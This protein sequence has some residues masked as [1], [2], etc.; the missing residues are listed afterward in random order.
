MESRLEQAH[1]Q[2]ET[3]SLASSTLLALYRA[4]SAVEDQLVEQVE[5]LIAIGDFDTASQ[6]WSKISEFNDRLASIFGLVID[7]QSAETDFEEL[8]DI[9]ESCSKDAR[10]SWGQALLFTTAAQRL[11]G[12]FAEAK[13]AAIEAQEVF[14]DLSEDGDEGDKYLFAMISTAKANRL[15]STAHTQQRVFKLEDAAV[16]YLEAK[17]VFEKLRD[18]LLESDDAPPGAIAALLYDL[19]EC[20]M[21]AE[22]VRL[23]KSF[24]DGNFETAIN[25][26]HAM[27][28]ITLPSDNSGVPKFSL[29]SAMVS[30]HDAMANLAYARAELA[31]N[32]REWDEALRQLTE[33]ER[34]WGELVTKALD[35]DIPQARQIADSAQAGASR[36]VG[37]CRQ[38]ITRERSLHTQ[39]AELQTENQQLQNKIFQLAGKVNVAFSGDYMPGDKYKFD[40]VGQAGVVGSQNTLNDIEMEQTNVE[41]A[42]PDIDMVALAEQLET[43][44]GKLKEEADGPESYTSLAEISK[45]ARAAEKSD[46]AST[47]QHLKAA[48]Q[49][50]LDSAKN[51][52]VPLAVSALK[53][54][55]GIQ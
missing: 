34:L 24:Y 25:H 52:G 49:W 4:E 27:Q 10:S 35:L 45:A 19:Y 43:L 3:G 23:Y 6:C 40:N 15:L 17:N 51:V 14:E 48:G 21:S 29:K 50:A 44:I 2:A 38:R 53:I 8:V 11:S 20:K 55:L 5:Q 46:K 37:S 26:A 9:R 28:Q 22:R 33:A 32:N 42:A 16:T 30:R 18:R 36:L 13:L 47:L 31:V 12:N 39:I 7:R 41:T 54:A 1:K